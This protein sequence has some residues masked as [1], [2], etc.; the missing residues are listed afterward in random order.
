M[1][2]SKH[3]FNPHFHNMLPLL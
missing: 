1:L 2:G 3:V